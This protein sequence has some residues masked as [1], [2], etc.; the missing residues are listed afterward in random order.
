MSW[1]LVA[2]TRTTNARGLRIR[3]KGGKDEVLLNPPRIGYLA[4]QTTRYTDQKSNPL[5]VGFWDS[6]G[7]WKTI[8]KFVG[9]SWEFVV[10]IN[11]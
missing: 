1:D 6:E 10:P 11:D 7:N 9:N 2:D 8:A 3:L 5:D 4:A